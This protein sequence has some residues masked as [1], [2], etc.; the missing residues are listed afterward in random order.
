MSKDDRLSTAYD[1]LSRISQY[2]NAYSQIV[3][4]VNQSFQNG[5]VSSIISSF[6]VLLNQIVIKQKLLKY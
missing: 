6:Y 5:L 1:N 4:Q 2:E 3:Y